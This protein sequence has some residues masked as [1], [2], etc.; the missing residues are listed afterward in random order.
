[1][2][3]LQVPPSKITTTANYPQPH[4]PGKVRVHSRHFPGKV[5]DVREKL[6][7][8]YRSSNQSD[9]LP[10]ADLVERYKGRNVVERCINKLKQW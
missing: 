4:F 2:E 5:L 1:M 6:L 10:T 7:A 8:L 3:R 9:R